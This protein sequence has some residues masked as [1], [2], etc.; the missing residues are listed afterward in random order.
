MENGN[1]HYFFGYCVGHG[2]IQLLRVS[3]L[4][5]CLISRFL[6]NGGYIRKHA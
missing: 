4:V 5:D 2:N 1:A 6:N 3:F